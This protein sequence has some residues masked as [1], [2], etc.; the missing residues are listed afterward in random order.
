MRAGPRQDK[1]LA[2][3]RPLTLALMLS[4]AAV[5][6]GCSGDIETGPPNKVDNWQWK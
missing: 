2:M 5:A 4:M 1:E 3:T 6:A